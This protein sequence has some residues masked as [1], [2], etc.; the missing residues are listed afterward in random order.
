MSLGAG[1]TGCGG[2][3]AG[4]GA[5]AAASSKLLRMPAAAG[6]PRPIGTQL[7]WSRHAFLVG[8]NV[9]A[10]QRT[11]GDLAGWRH[12]GAKISVD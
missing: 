6:L 4:G 2:T 1:D 9:K 5:T 10:A 3:G 7:G 11:V 12:G 8:S